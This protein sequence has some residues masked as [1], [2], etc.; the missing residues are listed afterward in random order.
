MFMDVPDFPRLERA[1]SKAPSHII[2]FGFVDNMH[3]LMAAS[4]FAVAKSGGLTTSECLALGV[5]MVVFNPIPGQE[6]RNAFHLIENGAG[7]WAHTAAN[8]LYKVETLLGDPE[9]L[10]RMQANARR[11]GRPDAAYRIADAVVGSREPKPR[12]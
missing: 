11:I 8:M 4:D 2:P 9:R 6:E 7:L 3:E 5:P 1:A 10:A 12:G